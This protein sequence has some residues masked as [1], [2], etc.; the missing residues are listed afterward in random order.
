MKV[1]IIELID[2]NYEQTNWFTYKVYKDEAKAKAK[3]LELKE[4]EDKIKDL[5]YKYPN[6]DRSKDIANKIKELE[7]QR[8]IDRGCD[9][10]FDVELYE[11]EVE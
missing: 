4:L 1:Y 7:S 2:W 6:W 9:Q 5:Y 8:E 10:Y 3:Y 11:M